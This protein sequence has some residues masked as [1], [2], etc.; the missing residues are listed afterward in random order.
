LKRTEEIEDIFAKQPSPVPEPA[1]EVTVIDSNDDDEYIQPLNNV[2]QAIAIPI[3]SI[4]F[5]LN[6]PILFFFFRRN[7]SKTYGAN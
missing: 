5:Y 3:A 2:S 6:C 7:Q 4:G 1:P